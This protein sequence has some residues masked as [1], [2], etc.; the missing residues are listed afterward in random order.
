MANINPQKL[1]NI[2]RTTLK[3]FS[4]GTMLEGI[5]VGLL[6][7]R[8]P[9]KLSMCIAYV[10]SI[11]KILSSTPI[12]MQ[13]DKFSEYF[14]N[15]F[16]TV[17]KFEKGKIIKERKRTLKEESKKE[18]KFKLDPPSILK[19]LPDRKKR[20]VKEPELDSD[21]EQLDLV[22]APSINDSSLSCWICNKDFVIKSTPAVCKHAY[23]EHCMKNYLVSKLKKGVC[24]ESCFQKD[25]KEPL[26]Y[27][28]IKSYYSDQEMVKYNA[29]KLCNE[30]SNGCK[31]VVYWCNECTKFFVHRRNDSP[32]C[33]ACK[34]EGVRLK[35][36]LTLPVKQTNNEE[37]NSKEQK[38]HDTI[39]TKAEHF[40]SR[41]IKCMKWKHK[42]TTT[43]AYRCKCRPKFL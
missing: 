35:K 15:I 33:L 25:C 34:S 28:F 3:E 16:Q 8:D 22:V 41:C 13:I 23:H 14:P 36:A 18:V 12:S 1:K 2:L 6:C 9:K 40:L 19:P 30:L 29:L 37:T 20:C 42:F 21:D 17:H 4:E 38:D 39:I 32:E 7:S 43:K 31:L 27:D 5:L 10:R 26:E 11:K 24:V